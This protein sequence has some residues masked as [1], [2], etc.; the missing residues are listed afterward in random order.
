MSVFS[1]YRAILYPSF[2]CT[3][4]SLDSVG[5]NQVVS[6]DSVE[7]GCLE[8]GF[9]IKSAPGRLSKYTKIVRF[10]PRFVVINALDTDIRVAQPTGF[11]GKSRDVSV[12]AGHLC[13]FHLPDIYGDRRLAIQLEGPWKRT[14]AFGID[15]ISAHTLAVKRKADLAALPHVQTRNQAVYKQRF[16]PREVGLW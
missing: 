11:G 10:M 1:L 5:V 9:K 2:R 6:V 3:P 4:F 12:S 16:P 8:L 13:P 15:Q 14:V 7:R